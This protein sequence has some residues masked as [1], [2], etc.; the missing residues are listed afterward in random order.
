MNL[1][2]I[3]LRFYLWLDFMDGVALSAALPQR[4]AKQTFQKIITTPNQRGLT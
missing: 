3:S 1:L 4:V 2:T